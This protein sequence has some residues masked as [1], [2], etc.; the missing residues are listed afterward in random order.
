MLLTTEPLSSPRFKNTA[1]AEN[2]TL[3]KDPGV[4]LDPIASAIM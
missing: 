2:P 1:F 4:V 3:L